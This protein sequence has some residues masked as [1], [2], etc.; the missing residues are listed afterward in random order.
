MTKLTNKVAVITGGSGAIGSTTAGLVLTEG[1]KV[2]LVDIR[3][4]ALQKV[5][6]ELNNPNISYVAA[7]VTKAADVQKYVQH[8]VNT[9]GEIDIFFNNA[10]VEGI[11]SHIIDSPE[12]AIDKLISVNVKV[13]WLGIK[14]RSEEHTT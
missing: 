7:D 8:T 9:F 6:S 10:G 14:Y 2:V 5:A 13:V 4:E 12:D 11:V 3:E 1:A